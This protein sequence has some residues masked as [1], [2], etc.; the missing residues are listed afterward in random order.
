MN[1][2]VINFKEFKDSIEHKNKKKI[3]FVD[4]IDWKNYTLLVEAES[5]QEAEEIAE[6]KVQENELTDVVPTQHLFE[7]LKVQ[8]E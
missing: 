6:R 2:N 7:I 4:F 8:C 3:Y 1:N 5:E